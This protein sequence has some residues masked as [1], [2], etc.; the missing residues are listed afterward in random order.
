MKDSSLRTCVNFKCVFKWEKNWK[1]FPRCLS[2]KHTCKTLLWLDINLDLSMLFLIRIWFLDEFHCNCDLSFDFL[3]IPVFLKKYMW[4]LI[5][6]CICIEQ[7]QFIQLDISKVYK[8]RIA[9]K[10][11]WCIWIINQ[12]SQI[13]QGKPKFFK[14]RSHNC[15]GNCSKT[16]RSD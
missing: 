16:S 6:R 5:I 11:I 12:S 7:E 10:Y 14:N 9:Q 2:W 15:S 1:G 3:R 4:A 13:F 8:E